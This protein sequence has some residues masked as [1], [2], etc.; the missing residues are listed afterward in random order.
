MSVTKTIKRESP[1]SGRLDKQLFAVLL[2]RAHAYAFH[3]S[4]LSSALPL[5]VL[6]DRTMAPSSV[7]STVLTYFI[8][9][10]RCFTGLCL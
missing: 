3:A 8:A 10:L 7:T 4:D 2:T 1:A 5:M 6:L 9:D